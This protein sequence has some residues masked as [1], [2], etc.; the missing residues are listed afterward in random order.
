[1]TPEHHLAPPLLDDRALNRALLARQLLLERSTL[2]P[3]EAIEHLVGMQAQQ[4]TPPYFGLLAR[5]ADFDPDEL[6]RL[7]ADRRVVR[8]AVM[9]STVHLV[10]AQDCLL[11]RPVMQPAL[12]RALTPGSRFGRA[13]AGI[14][15]DELDRESRGLV[16]AEPLTAAQIAAALRPQWPG[17]PADAI[18][19]AVR[20]R[21]PLVQV[22]PRGQWRRSGQA[23][24]T[25]AEHWLGRPL[26]PPDVAAVVRRYLAAYGPASVADAQAWSGLTGLRATFEVLR[27]ELLTFRSVSGSELFDLPEAPRPPAGQPVPVRLLPEFDSILL[28]HAER[29]RM[30]DPAHRRLIF[31]EN[32]I[33][34]ACVLVD[35][36]V[37]AT[38]KLHTS[39]ASAVVQVHLLPG[40]PLTD[41]DT[42]AIHLE[43][44]RVLTWAAPDAAHDIRVCAA[45]PE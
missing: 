5:L 36:F 19:Y 43:A 23:R 11:L 27:P 4:P 39:A 7:Y 30:F 37:R 17:V 44:Q 3:L 45:Q 40:P 15:L 20:A 13:L 35:G 25:S 6:S 14:D 16:E 1:M 8:I 21:V 34:H 33:I 42:A 24:C 31:T 12:Y 2:S 9:R 26:Q 18:A 38:W 41:Q 29:A 32:G 28:S 22:P 10:S